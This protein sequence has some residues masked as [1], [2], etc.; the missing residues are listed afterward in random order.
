ML[1]IVLLG[2]L[3]GVAALGGLFARRLHAD[4]QP[5]TGT[6]QFYVGGH[7]LAIDKAMIRSADL[8]EGGAVNRL[9]LVLIWP[10]L[11]GGAANMGPADAPNLIFVALEDAT[12]R[13][14]SPDDIDPAGRPVELYARFLE[15]D[16]ATGPGGLV[17]RPFRKAS[18]YEGEQL[19]VSS[20]DERLFSARCPQDLASQ[21]HCLWQTRL[22]NLDLIVRFRPQHLAEW[23]HLSGAIRLLMPKLRAKG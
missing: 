22:D 3:I 11:A 23:R 15:I 10:T 2:F 5:I 7:K 4:R 9:D 21:D 20:P 14:R 1:R 17:Q 18:P 13:A 12:A 8:R 16:A 19:F 6:A